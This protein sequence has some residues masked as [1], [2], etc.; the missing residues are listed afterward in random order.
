ML[1]ELGGEVDASRAF[2]RDRS[3]VTARL[4]SCPTRSMLP[5]RP[6]PLLRSTCSRDVSIGMG[7]AGRMADG[8]QQRL[9]PAAIS[10]SM[11]L[12]APIL[13]AKWN[14]VNLREH[15]GHRRDAPQ[16]ESR[17]V[18]DR[19]GF[20][21]RGSRAAGE[22][23]LDAPQRRGKGLEVSAVL[24]QHVN[25]RPGAPPRGWSVSAPPVRASGGRAARQ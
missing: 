14:A 25:H 6:L 22:W 21:L 8:C 24:D 2:V 18:R 10:A 4:A 20:V 1:V 5:L 3:R 23:R 9:E 11:L 19:S 17:C 15:Q 12:S 13:H 7:S 16:P